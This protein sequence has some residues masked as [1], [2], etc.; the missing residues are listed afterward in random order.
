MAVLNNY[1]NMRITS[2]EFHSLGIT[3]RS[4]GKDINLIALGYKDTELIELNKLGESE[5]NAFIRHFE[6]QEQIQNQ[7]EL[8][9]VLLAREQNK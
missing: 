2:K 7:I 3:Y 9:K 8:D 6:K 5:R 4:E 1:I